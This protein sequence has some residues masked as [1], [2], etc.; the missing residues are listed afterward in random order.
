MQLSS[1][2]Q[3][4][5]TLAAPT[6]LIRVERLSRIIEARAK[7][8]VVLD[9]V[10]FTVP[11]QSLFAI[12]GPSGSGKSTLLNML[13][14]IDRPTSGC[15]IFAGKELRAISENDLARWRGKHVGIVFQ[16]F[17]LIPRSQ[18]WKMCCWPSNWEEEADCGGSNG[19]SVP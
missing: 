13:T 9:D 2:K 17:Q 4:S 14:G 8:T 11:V 10:T 3:D 6:A 18:Q 15:V 5:G 1:I 19:A 12:N 16:F 7:K